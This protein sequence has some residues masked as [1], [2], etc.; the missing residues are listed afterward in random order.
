[1]PLPL[2]LNIHPDVVDTVGNVSPLTV[3]AVIPPT[4]SNPASVI[5]ARRSAEVNPLV[6]NLISVPVLAVPTAKLPP[7]IN[8]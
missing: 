5:V 8:K 3:A 2:L 7:S 4:T 6:W 1:M